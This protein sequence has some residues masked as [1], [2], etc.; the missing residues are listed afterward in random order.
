MLF[1]SPLAK[2]LHRSTSGGTETRCSPLAPASGTKPLSAAAERSQEPG[3][4]LQR[5]S[6][7]PPA[8]SCDASAPG[9][10]QEAAGAAPR[11]L[12][13]LA[14]SKQRAAVAAAASA[15]QSPAPPPPGP[16]RLRLPSA[17]APRSSSRLSFGTPLAA[18]VPQA[19]PGSACSVPRQPQQAAGTGPASSFKQ[20]AQELQQRQAAARQATPAG[21]ARPGSVRPGSARGAPQQEQQG[22]PPQGG[23]QR[24]RQQQ[25][26]QQQALPPPPTASLEEAMGQLR[27]LAPAAAGAASAAAATPGLKIRSRGEWCSGGCG[28]GVP[29]LL[30]HLPVE[31]PCMQPGTLPVAVS[32]SPPVC[33]F[34]RRPADAAGH[35]SW[36]GRSDAKLGVGSSAGSRGRRRKRTGLPAGRRPCR[37]GHPAA[38]DA[39]RA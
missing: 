39:G 12:Q 32:P 34:Q 24:E 5:N 26:R 29:G 23:Q 35:P 11:S 17:G 10:P 18:G 22:Q 4:A 6:G 27:L 38:A 16:A 20:R 19:T 7:L 33:V 9:A 37:G 31:Q 2:N 36:R 25:E 3:G 21:S 8:A 1:N 13:Q 30:P 15:M 28:T 14:V